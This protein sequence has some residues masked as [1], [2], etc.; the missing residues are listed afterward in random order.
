[1]LI[2]GSIGSLLSIVAVAYKEK[3][4]SELSKLMLR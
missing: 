1:M 2:T 3:G 4:A